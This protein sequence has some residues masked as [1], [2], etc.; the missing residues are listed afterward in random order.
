MS[1]FSR[2][3]VFHILGAGVVFL[4]IILIGNLIRQVHFHDTGTG[5]GGASIAHAVTETEAE[6]MG[7]YLKGKKIGYSMSQIVPLDKDYLIQEE[8]VM[9]LNLLGQ[10]SVLRTFTRAVVDS[11]FILKN[12]KVRI[13][14]GI[15]N[16]AISGKVEKDNIIIEAENNAKSRP[17]KIKLSGPPVIGSGLS[18]IFKGKALKDGE[19]SDFFLFDPSTMTQKKIT[20]RVAGK[21]KVA[22]NDRT[23]EAWRL[24]TRMWGQ[25]LLFWVDEGGNVLREQG[26]MGLTLVRSDAEHA[27]QDL[28]GNDVYDF[29]RM[30]SVPVKKTLGDV[31][32]LSFLKIKVGGLN[33]SGFEPADLNGERQKWSGELLEIR[34]EKLPRKP[35]YALPFPDSSENMKPFLRPEWTIQSDNPM[36]RD[37]AKEIAGKNSNP[38]SVARKLMEWVYKNVEKKPVISVPDA[39]E[40]LQT[41]VGDCN[42]HAVLLVALL[43]AAGIPARQCVGLVYVQN[44]FYYH[45]WTEAFLG[46][47]IS[48]DATLNQMPADVSHIKLLH[49]GLQE[50]AKI[51]SVI[52]KISLEIEEFQ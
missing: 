27:A 16:F 45:A 14:S 40:V 1:V 49:G 18:Y 47:W 42:E 38:V 2:R 34:K 11:H 44:R 20:I 51:I 10:P 26:M 46:S 35:P 28:A 33:D 6:W 50:Q 52:N 21:E 3:R 31:T 17:Q 25:D 36:I 24:E 22:L 13:S 29:Y 37:L 15:V 39:L 5:G 12:F 30:S 32:N 8:I 7:I 4:W 9:R 23:Y 48:M 19:T 43:R 41:R